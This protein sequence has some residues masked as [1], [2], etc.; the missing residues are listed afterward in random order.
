[1]ADSG[2]DTW[3]AAAVVGFGALNTAFWGASH[4]AAVVSGGDFDARWAKAPIALVRIFATP[5]DPDGAWG[6][7]PGTFGPAGLF[8]FVAGCVGAAT[9]ML[10]VA[11]WM[12]WTRLDVGID[13]SERLGVVP[14]A[15]MATKNELSPLRVK[16]PVEGRFVF[17]R[18]MGHLVATE[19]PA[20]QTARQ[21]LRRAKTRVSDRTSIMIFGPT[22]SGKT[23]T[24]VPGIIEW[25]LPAVISSVKDDLM[26]AT[27]PRR[28]AIGE[29]FL[30]DPFKVI[31]QDLEGVVRVSW[32]PISCSKTIDGAIDAAQTL[33]DAAGSEDLTSGGYWSDRGATLLWPLL[34]AAAIDNRSMSDVMRWLARQDGIEEDTSEVNAI[35]RSAMKA[36][37]PVGLQASIAADQFEGWAA[38]DPR[39]R[40]DMNST[41]Q[42]L[43]SCWNS[44]QAAASSDPRL[45]PIDIGKVLSGRNTLYIV[46]P[47]GRGDQFAPLFGGL[48]GDL[49]RDQTYRVAHAAGQRIGPLLAVLDEAANT[50]LR[51]LPEVASTC[52]GVGVQL[53]T[54][55]Q[56]RSQV[57]ALYKDHAQSLLNN[58]A[59]KIFFAGQSD[60]DTLEYASMLCGEEEVTSNSASADLN[61]G[62]GRRS[63]S[64]QAVTKR[65]VPPDML[66]LIPNG[67]ALLIH[68]TLRP[69]HMVGRRISE[70]PG[71]AAL[72]VS[73]WISSGKDGLRDVSETATLPTSRASRVGEFIVDDGMKHAFEAAHISVDDEVI[74]HMSLGRPATT[75]VVFDEV[76]EHAPLGYD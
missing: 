44:M 18:V 6:A 39:P 65:L 66:R 53:V 28:S 29:V 74:N 42:S 23:A 33:A 47:L 16:A 13:R 5:G 76:E 31:K 24:I 11:V 25:D 35:L 61:L 10:L 68:N 50:P 64:A 22:R 63:A 20:T 45:P 48:F 21:I 56:D 19:D 40:S 51:W 54:I 8:W 69:F 1:M 9:L 67:T 14:E 73:R 49:I 71:V 34:F 7:A 37:G 58:H 4:L 41:A 2:G 57:D 36:G 32:S 60:P 62:S 52:A 55:W 70:E 43:V 59:T 3:A 12:W 17:G 46:Q 75:A 27:L 26:M 38:L 15:R 72:L 30:F